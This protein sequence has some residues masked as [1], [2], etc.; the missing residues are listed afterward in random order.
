MMPECR[1]GTDG[2]DYRKKCRCRSSRT[3]FSPAFIYD[4]SISHSKKNTISTFNY[5]QFGRAL[6]IPFTTTKT[7]SMNVQGVPLFK[8]AGMSDC[9]ASS[10]SGTG[11]NKNADAGTIPI[12]E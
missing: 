5:L 12:P 7:S 9:P 6:G 10:Q 2:A 1:Y 11:M 3:N 4:F 8:N